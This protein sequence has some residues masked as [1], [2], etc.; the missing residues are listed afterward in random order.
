MYL[1]YRK[2]R[3]DA[4]PRPVNVLPGQRNLTDSRTMPD[5]GLDAR[6]D[7]TPDS[8]AAPVKH[9][10]GSQ[11][12]LG[13]QADSPGNPVRPA[14]LSSRSARDRASAAQTRSS[15]CCRPL[16]CSSA[17]AAAAQLLRVRA[18]HSHARPPVRPSARSL[19][20]ARPTTTNNPGTR[21]SAHRLA[22]LPPGGPAH[23]PRASFPIA[24]QPSP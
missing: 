9:G 20:A 10:D 17:A 5:R 23:E 19:A 1:P 14:R 11:P 2:R 4:D 12:Q 16:R 8:T 24:K 21:P 6:L 15:S 22:R 18:A 13:V 3:F 7:A